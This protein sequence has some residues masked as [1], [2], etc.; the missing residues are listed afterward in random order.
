[1]WNNQPEWLK[2]AAV[3]A[4]VSFAHWLLRRPLRALPLKSTPRAKSRPEYEGKPGG[5]CFFSTSET[6]PRLD[7]VRGKFFIVTGAAQGCGEGVALALAAEGASG[8]SLVDVNA[9]KGLAVQQAIEA[10]GCK[11]L[12]VSVDLSDATDCARVVAAHD[13]AFGRI[14]GLINCAATTQRGHWEDTSI[15]MWDYVMRLNVRAPF[16]L[17]QAAARLMERDGVPGAI[18]NIGSVHAHGGSPKL[19]ACA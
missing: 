12:F 18:V 5:H 16:M 2:L 14:D 9:S 10:L 3:A 6:R 7:R 13:A 19:V 17:M 11:A 15:E 8:I 4:G 1:M